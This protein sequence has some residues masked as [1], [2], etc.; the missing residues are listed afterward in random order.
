MTG[1]SRNGG[2]PHSVP[3]ERA[4]LAAVWGDPD[5]L[6]ATPVP[7][8]A[9]YDP[10]HVAI[11]AAVLALTEA[12]RPIGTHDVERE[13][14]RR[15]E[16]KRAGGLEYLL[17]LTARIEFDAASPAKRILELARL[18]ELR[19]RAL[20]VVAACESLDLD[21]AES[22]AIGFSE[23]L[24]TGTDACV[25]TAHEVATA[26]VQSLMGQAAAPRCK[27]GIASI[28]RAIGFVSAGDMILIGADTGVGK[29]TT[30]L[31]MAQTLARTGTIV[32]FVSCEDGKETLGGKVVSF[33]SGVSMRKMRTGRVSPEEVARIDAALKRIE[34]LGVILAF[35]IG[36]TDASVA[37]HMAR[38]VRNRG[39]GIV[40]VDYV[41]TINPSM[42]G[43]SRKEDVRRIA[44]RLKGTAAHLG[45]PLVLASQL[46]RP[47]EGDRRGRPSK[48]DLKEAGDLEN[49][50]E[51]IL[52]LW[53]DPPDDEDH[54]NG[55]V[56]KS[57]WGGD[58]MQ[59]RFARQGGMLVEML[60]G[61]GHWYLPVHDRD[62]T[63]GI[64][65]SNGMDRTNGIDHD[66][67]EF[68]DS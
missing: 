10:R 42:P 17:E 59:V 61:N 14:S 16:L 52:M 60:R 29:S 55:Y 36:G 58:G 24:H 35:D 57:K 27:T 39:A 41:Q 6:V 31:A 43:Q 65:H 22:A 30:M 66:P 56:P 15:G 32:G 5:R 7:P 44:S 40:F 4:Y 53:R 45:V 48:H 9:F 28:D 2:P 21:H 3:A 11:V 26:A 68:M 18:R 67:S 34:R 33:E 23:S 25:Y 49:M 47:P 54:V 64:D 63:N 8:T 19:E 20:R 13:L 50:A 38:L 12:Q 46:R 62:R 37:Q 51:L 1:P